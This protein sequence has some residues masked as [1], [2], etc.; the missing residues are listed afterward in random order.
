MDIDLGVKISILVLC[1]VAAVFVAWNLRTSIVRF[2]ILV[3]KFKEN[4]AYVTIAS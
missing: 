3:S 4:V 2:L 1:E